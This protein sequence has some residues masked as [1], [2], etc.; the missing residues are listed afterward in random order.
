MDTHEKKNLDD[1]Y[2]IIIVVSSL[3]CSGS[4]ITK[5]T[6]FN[7]SIYCYAYTLHAHMQY[8]NV[9]DCRSIHHKP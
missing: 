5:D 3:Q 2:I 7:S 8:V 4:V 1:W 6:V 9:V